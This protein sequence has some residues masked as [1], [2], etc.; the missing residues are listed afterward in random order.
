MRQVTSIEAYESVKPYIPTISERIVD[1]I[2][3]WGPDICDEIEHQL[4]LSHQTCSA[5]IR[6]LVKQGILED[7]G[8]KSLTRSGRRAIMWKLTEESHESVG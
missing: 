4:S 5:C 7:S 8:L 6:G 1:Y 3:E 2:S